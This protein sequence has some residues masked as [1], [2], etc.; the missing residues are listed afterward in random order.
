MES[1]I[2]IYALSVGK[3][4]DPMLQTQDV[5]QVAAVQFIL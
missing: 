1:A 3:S 2:K 5:M 4:S